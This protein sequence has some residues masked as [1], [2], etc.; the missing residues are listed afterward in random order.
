MMR[1]L[2]ATG[3]QNEQTLSQP[4]SEGATEIP[5][6]NA[7]T[8]FAEGDHLFISE[9]DGSELEYLGIA[10]S[11]STTSVTVARPVASAKSAGALLWKPVAVF[12]WEV[13]RSSPLVRTYHSGVEVQRSVGGVLYSTQVSDPFRTESLF[14]ERVTRENYQQY[15]QWVCDVIH[16]GLDA[17]TY[18]DE[19]GVV[20]VVKVLGP[21]LVQKEHYPRLVSVLVELQ[22]VTQGSYQ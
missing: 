17:F 8:Y 7:S 20:S 3:K 16:D 19:E 9:S 21:K 18:V 12:Q 5:V 22:Y 13:G 15:E 11:V 10:T 4:I 6:A 14:F 2:F 1:P